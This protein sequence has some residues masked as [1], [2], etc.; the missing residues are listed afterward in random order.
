[1]VFMM[2]YIINMGIKMYG[3]IALIF[4]VY[5]IY[6]FKIIYQFLLLLMKK[7][8]AYMEACH[9]KSKLLTKLELYKEMLRFLKKVHFVI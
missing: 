8:Y 3:H 4:L 6:I 7:Y 2:K 1:M 9:H 5:I